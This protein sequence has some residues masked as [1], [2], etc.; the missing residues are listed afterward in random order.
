MRVKK[1]IVALAAPIA[2]AAVVLPISVQ[3]VIKLA[4]LPISLKTNVLEVVQMV[5][6]QSAEY[7]PLANLLVRPVMALPR[8]AFHAIVHRDEVFC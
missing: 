5:L 7:A 2:L 8:S 3:V 6:Y 1:E 4:L